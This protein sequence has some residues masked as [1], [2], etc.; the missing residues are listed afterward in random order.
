MTEIATQLRHDWSLG[1]INALF[2]TPFNDLLFRAHTLHRA[3]H[4]PNAVQISTLLSI[5]TGACPEDCAYCPQSAHYDTGLERER[6]L[7]LSEILEHAQAAK[8][9]GASRFCMGAAWRNPTDKQLDKV[10]EMIQTVKDQ[11][12][13]TCVTLGMLS[14]S[15]AQ[16]LKQVGLDYYNHN[17]DTSPEFYGDI[18]T[19]RDYQDRLDTLEHVR[20][21]QI[22]VCC[23]GIVGMGESQ[24]DR[25]SLLQQLANLPSHPESVPINMLVQVEGTP[26]FNTEPLDSIEFVRTIAVARILMPQSMVRLSAGRENM[27]KETQAL[28]FFAGANSIFYGEKLLTT[29]NPDAAQDEALFQQLGLRPMRNGDMAPMVA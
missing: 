28:C 25:A 4:D 24:Q 11:G 21:A 27:S 23:G 15:Q 29:P 2:D 12:L 18:I 26:L 5:K 8:A 17:L 16:R 20:D 13:E 10:I 14:Q 19:T 1:E 7:P 9:K 22:N 6:L 3:Q